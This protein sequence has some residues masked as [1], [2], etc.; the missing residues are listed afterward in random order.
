MWSTRDMLRVGGALDRRSF[1][2]FCATM[3]TALAVPPAYAPAIARALTTAKRP[4]LVWLQFSDCAGCTESFLRASN[5]GVSELVLNTF[6]IDYHETLMAASGK[7]AEELLRDTV[8]NERGEYIVVVEGA[9]P[10][11]DNGVYCTIGGRSALDIA[12]E[13]CKNA[14][15]VLTVGACAFDGGWPAANPNPTG[16][17]GLQ[18]AV[19]GLRVVNLPGCPPNPVNIT[20]TLVHFLTFGAMPETDAL[21][22]P[23]F[24]YGTL[25][26]DSCERRAHY[27]AG[28]FVE[29][30]G[31][32]AHR[33]GWCLYELG[34][35]GPETHHNC[36]SVRWNDGT[37]WPIGAGHGCIGC[38]E[39]RFWDVNAPFYRR[40]PDVPG[41]GVQSTANEIGLGIVG[42]TAAAVATHAVISIVRDRLKPEAV[43]PAQKP[44]PVEPVHPK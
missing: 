30:W 32:E 28:E 38:S 43:E 10:T 18:G 19:G 33:K 36:A 11:K 1:L 42:V 3:A 16:A 23:L 25:I 29:V 12:R 40:L 6:S 7:G 14:A 34:C 4:V 44:K 5:P 9:I 27:D 24:A 13:V 31:D 39:P 20:A 8:G 21:G 26:H 35:K 41:F 22:R 17:A 37:N 15:A 2:A